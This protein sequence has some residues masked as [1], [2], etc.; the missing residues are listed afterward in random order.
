MNHILAKEV[1]KD[2]AV[3]F[4]GFGLD[5]VFGGMDLFRNAYIEKLYN[6][7]L[8]DIKYVLDSVGGNKYYCKYLLEKFTDTK[9][10]ADYFI[11]YG[12]YYGDLLND[13]KEKEVMLEFQSM[14]DSFPQE[15]TDLST[16]IY[17][18]VSTSLAKRYAPYNEPYALQ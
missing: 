15:S 7:G 11:K 2:C 13:A 5:Y 8:V 18:V 17:Y 3:V 12:E 9:L 10:T 1:K 14:V 6:T 4:S 16:Q